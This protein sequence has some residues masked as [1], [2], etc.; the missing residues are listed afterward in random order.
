MGTASPAP[1]RSSRAACT[2]VRL[3]A[4]PEW[5]GKYVVVLHH[6]GQDVE[7]V[8]RGEVGVG[9]GDEGRQRHCLVVAEDLF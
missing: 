4:G 5:E 7:G 3:D 8:G 1:R 6:L 2:P 9:R